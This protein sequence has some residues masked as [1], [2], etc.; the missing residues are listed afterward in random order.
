MI[1][2]FKTSSEIKDRKIKMAREKGTFA[3]CDKCFMLRQQVWG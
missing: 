1:K 2:V 3:T